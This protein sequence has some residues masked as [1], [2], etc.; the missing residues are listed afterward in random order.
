MIRKSISSNTPKSNRNYT[1]ISSSKSGRKNLSFEKIFKNTNDEDEKSDTKVENIPEK[2]KI[3]SQNF[4]IP[5]QEAENIISKAKI[6][7]NC[8]I[9]SENLDNQ[10][11]LENNSTVVKEILKDTT[12]HVNQKNLMN[13]SIFYDSVPSSVYSIRTIIDGVQRKHE[14][15]NQLST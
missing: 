8:T 2:K 1:S 15:K 3:D 10:D 13:S 9:N 7:R 6:N 11:L 12:N 5:F 4:S 14:K